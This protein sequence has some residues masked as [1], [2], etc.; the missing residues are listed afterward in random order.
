M[1]KCKLFA[2]RIYLKKC[3]ILNIIM[4]LLLLNSKKSYGGAVNTK[5]NIIFR[6]FC[7]ASAQLALPNICRGRNS[8]H[9]LIFYIF[10]R[11]VYLH[12]GLYYMHFI[13]CVAFIVIFLVFFISPY[14]FTHQIQ[15]LWLIHIFWGGVI[16]SSK[17]LDL[18][19]LLL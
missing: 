7:V 11:F 2:E 3:L 5:T 14:H 17:Y 18:F 15:P 12:I 10:I 6:K 1:H 8:K 4:I 13:C 19:L 9:I 16:S